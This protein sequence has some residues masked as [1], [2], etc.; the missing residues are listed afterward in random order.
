MTLPLWC[1]CPNISNFSSQ[2]VRSLLRI[3]FHFNLIDLTSNLH[4]KWVYFSY[5]PL[6][7]QL[8]KTL[9]WIF[10][11][12]PISLTP[13]FYQDLYGP[14][15][16]SPYSRGRKREEG[17]KE[18]WDGSSFLFFFSFLFFGNLDKFLTL[19][20]SDSFLLSWYILL[21]IFLTC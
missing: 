21:W 17:S 5:F 2:T 18:E 16:F 7:P 11:W 15:K 3:H 8:F 4:I 1:L 12:F 19:Y 14:V 6:L 10:Q 20:F 9:L 13:N